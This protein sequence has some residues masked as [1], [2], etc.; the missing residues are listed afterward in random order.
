MTFYNHA[1]KINGCES[2][3]TILRTRILLSAGTL[4]RMRG[5][6]LPKLIAFGN[7]DGAVRKGQCGKE[8]GWIDCVRNDVRAF[9]MAGDWKVTTLVAEIWVEMV[10]E[11]GQRFMPSEAKKKRRGY[12]SLG[13]ERGERD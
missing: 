11:D 1:L 13:E 12:T 9:D 8:K 10:T 4:T 2:I 6:R 7:L 5:G 3:E